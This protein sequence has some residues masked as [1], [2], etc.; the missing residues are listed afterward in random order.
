MSDAQHSCQ[1][2]GNLVLGLVGA[3]HVVNELAEGVDDGVSVDLPFLVDA[4]GNLIG[5]VS[6]DV[7][8]DGNEVLLYARKRGVLANLKVDE[9]VWDDAH[10]LKR[11]SLNTCSWE[12]LDDPAL[13]L[14]LVALNFLLHEL[15]HDFIVN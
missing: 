2:V 11:K 8:I 12:A 7:L 10:L 6:V 15:D 9:F 14:L 3:V 1:V 4:F 13:V 5:S